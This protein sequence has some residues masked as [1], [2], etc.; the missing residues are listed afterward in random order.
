MSETQTRDRVDT[1][2]LKK[3][4]P[5]ADVVGCY[6]PLRP[7]GRTLVGRCP[8]HND[9]GRPNLTV[10]TATDTWYCF[11]C[12]IGGDVIAFVEK[13]ANVPFL[14]AV[15][16]IDGNKVPSA[17]AC[18]EQSRR[19]TPRHWK[20]PAEPAADAD[21]Q[22]I[23]QAAAEAYYFALL[24]N[25]AAVEYLRKRRISLQ[26]AH[27]HMVGLC[28]GDRLMPYLR[29]HRLPVGKA[30]DMGLLGNDREFFTGRLTIAEVT[31]TGKVLH[32]TGRAFARPDQDP[33][34]LSTPGLPKPLYG[35]ARAKGAKRTPILTES[36]TDFL[37]LSEWGYLPL[38]SLGTG[39]KEEH[40]A[41]L[42]SLPRVAAVP[43]NDEAGWEAVRRWKEALPH[44]LITPL[45]H[46]FKDINELAQKEWNEAR[47]MFTGILE[48]A[49][50][51]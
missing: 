26:T 29:Y 18:P 33:K 43:H 47:Q 37:T 24:N 49:R 6:I 22:R 19:V 42:R 15:Q 28:E 32:L 23:L 1:E 38:S 51:G 12:N 5:I 27:R 2:A 21:H 3:E 45:P 9:S 17:R 7:S 10:F 31:P 46:E 44:L 41:M 34:Y 30:C 25:Q 48:G 39:L 35:W 16:M 50:R 14:D 20:K 11:R 36:V 40:V 4:H 13:I 8:F